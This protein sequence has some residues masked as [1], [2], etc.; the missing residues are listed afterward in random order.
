MPGGPCKARKPL[1]GW[2]P[3]QARGS[4]SLPS[5]AAAPDFPPA[6]GPGAAPPPAGSARYCPRPP[7]AARRARGAL[8]ASPHGPEGISSC[9][10][11]AFS[12]RRGPQLPPARASPPQRLAWLQLST[13]RGIFDLVAVLWRVSLINPN[14]QSHLQ[15]VA[16][17]LVRVLGTGSLSQRF[18]VLSKVFAS[19]ISDEARGLLASLLF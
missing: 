1:H 7:S 12:F 14:S 18:L 5:P 17:A 16:V 4:L 19:Y 13:L 2:E 3:L 10:H 11:T 15:A 6:A 8:S 9:S